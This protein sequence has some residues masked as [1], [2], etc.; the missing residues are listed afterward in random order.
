MPFLSASVTYS[1][2]SPSIEIMTTGAVALL[3]R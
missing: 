2:L 1:G 3:S